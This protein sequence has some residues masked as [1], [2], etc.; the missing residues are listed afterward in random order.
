MRQILLPALAA[1]VLL[2]AG[3]GDGSPAITPIPFVNAWGPR[4]ESADPLTGREL[5]GISLRSS[6]ISTGTTLLVRCTFNSAVE[7]ENGLDALIAW[8]ED[9]GS[10]YRPTV[11][12]RFDDGDAV[13]SVWELGSSME[14]AA[15]F[16][17]D[18]DAF[19][20]GMKGAS[21]LTATVWKQ[22]RTTITAQWEVAGFRDA[23]RPIEE[24][25]DPN[26]VPSP[27]PTT[28]RD[29]L[30]RYETGNRVSSS[31]AVAGGIV[32]IGS[33]GGY[34]YAVD[35]ASGELRWRYETAEDG[36][37]SSPTVV[38]GV[39][40]IGSRDKYLY[41]VDAHSGELQWRYGTGA[42]VNSSPA[43][44]GGIV[45]AGSYDHFLHAVDAVSG[46]LRWRYET[47]D[48]VE[49]SPAVADGIVYV[50]SRDNF[51]YAVD[52][53]S[54]KLRWRY[55]T[56]DE[57]YSSP[58]V[59]DGTVYVGSDDSYVYALDA[60]SGELRWRYATGDWV[61]SSPAVA[62]GVV[63]VGS[64][65]GYVYAVDAAS[66]ELRRRYA[67]GGRVYSSPVVAEG[68]VY[69]GSH[70]GYVYAAEGLTTVEEG[71]LSQ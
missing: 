49:S 43:V 45:Y 11:A 61:R 47:G 35:A 5:A 65:D 48:E 63:Y 69:F 13:E 57:V 41:A 25:C 50:G 39:V 66:G 26:F 56:G 34:L 4:A 6:G 28:I 40:Y 16:A 20:S 44:A 2:A 37:S 33:Y 19:I 15:T 1:V 70:D 12:V 46:E 67:T 24:R 71:S 52:A 59:A 62:D 10:D 64:D 36:V 14:Q 54:G 31:P 9:L 42:W 18:A 27:T 68:V 30:W 22:D 32:Y 3:C 23:V 21:R 55:A 7:G 17:P 58:A 51:L 29:Y 8:D 60:A 38:D 53:A